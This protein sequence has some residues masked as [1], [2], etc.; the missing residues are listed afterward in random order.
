MR[1]VVDLRLLQSPIERRMFRHRRTCLPAA[2]LGLAALLSSITTAAAAPLTKEQQKCAVSMTARLGDAT[3]ANAGDALKC[4]AGAAKGK[5][6]GTIESCVAGVP[7]AKAAAASRKVEAAFTKLCIGVSAKPP[8][9]P[10][11]PPFGIS[12]PTAVN[13]VG[14]GIVASVLHDVF[15][16]DLDRS[17]IRSAT[18]PN[19]AK[20]QLAVAKTLAKCRA[21]MLK[22]FAGCVKTGLKSKT[23]PFDQ[24]DDVADCIDADPK[25]SVAK[26]CNL[27]LETRPGKFKVDAVRKT[28]DAA[29]PPSIRPSSS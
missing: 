19:G 2:V 3:A 9:L 1:A 15:G 8:G 16:P 20:C 25:G 21:A 17:A 10:K 28:L 26:A 4:L 12:D 29:A 6:A 24:A 27:L 11:R 7:P 23:A 22:S 5:L 13:A 14:A 18:D